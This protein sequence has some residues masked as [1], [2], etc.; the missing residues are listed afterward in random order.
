MATDPLKFNYRAT[1]PPRTG[2]SRSQSEIVLVGGDS[3]SNGANDWPGPLQSTYGHTVYRAAVSGGRLDRIFTEMRTWA[4]ANW[5]VKPGVVLVQGGINN[6]V[7]SQTAETMKSQLNQ[8]IVYFRKLGAIPVVLSLC[9][10]GSSSGWTAGR[11]TEA[12]A[13]N[14]W[15]LA[16]TDLVTVDVY[17]PLESAPGSD[18][19]AAGYD[20]GDGLHPNTTGMALIAQLVDSVLDN[21]VDKN[22]HL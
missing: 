17:T 14:S 8:I 5:G 20:S 1:R 2:A 19:L 9:P 10:F 15:L 21:V 22:C 18:I 6:I 11:Q 12:D 7:A 16:R 13:F 4:A 3:F